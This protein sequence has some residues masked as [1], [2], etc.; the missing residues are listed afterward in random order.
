MYDDRTRLITP[1]PAGFNLNRVLLAVVLIIAIF[2]LFVFT[3]A[4]WWMYLMSFAVD[5]QR[6]ASTPQMTMPQ[7]R[8]SNVR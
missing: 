3:A 8:T 4:S 7:G 6:T 2:L 5:A 1:R